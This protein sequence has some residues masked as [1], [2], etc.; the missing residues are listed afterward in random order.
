MSDAVDVSG[1]HVAGAPVSWGLC[2]VPGWGY[3][4]SAHRVLREM[5][6]VGLRATE[7]GPPH[8]LPED[9]GH[10]KE[11][12]ADHGMAA[13]GGFAPIVLHDPNHDPVAEFRSFL[14]GCRAAGADTMV[15]AAATGTDGYDRRPELT[16]GGWRALVDN[17]A[18]AEMLAADSGINAVLHPHIGTMIEV[19]D[20]IHRLLD[21]SSIPLCLDTGHL[22]VAGGNPVELARQAGDRVA[23]VHLKDV[24]LGLAQRV[25]SGDI[26]YSSAVREGMYLP[27][28][29]GDVDLE[30]LIHQLGCYFYTGWYV[31]EQDTMLGGAP[32]G[33]G[34]ISDV[35]KSL[36]Y[37]TTLGLSGA[38][39]IKGPPESA[40]PSSSF[41]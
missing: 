25:Q 4:M 12:L 41:R 20:E 39:A 10:A 27:L 14:A 28:G 26:A 13:V 11:L 38:E 2:E 33:Q 22:L 5:H 29:D 6:E 18:T 17:L 34:P 24:D 30:E 1:P 9:R 16:D 23:H 19:P 3:Q 40:R 35:R 36:D 8:F 31:L 32:I 21:R 7:F 37:L 15:I